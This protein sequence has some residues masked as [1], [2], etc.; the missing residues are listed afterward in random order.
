M[1]KSGNYLV[2]YVQSGYTYRTHCVT[3]EKAQSLCILNIF[4][5]SQENPRCGHFLAFVIKIQHRGYF[6]VKHRW[7]LFV[8]HTFTQLLRW[9]HC[10]TSLF[11]LLLLSVFPFPQLYKLCL[12]IMRPIQNSHHFVDDIFKCILL[13]ENFGFLIIKISLKFIPKGPKHWFGWSSGNK[14]NL[15]Y[16]RIY[17]SLHLNELS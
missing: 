1:I 9:K 15:V 14:V 7:I 5:Q 10:L 8:I 17:A 6:L 11:F 2:Y 12:N 4:G 13:N 3:F 16:W